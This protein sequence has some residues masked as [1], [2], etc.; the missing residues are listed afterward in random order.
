MSHPPSVDPSW[1]PPAWTPP[2]APTPAGAWTPWG[3]W[4]PAAGRPVPPPPLPAP[5]ASPGR[6]GRTV[7]AATALGAAGLVTATVLG[8][9]VLSS[10]ADELG[11]GIGA[12][13]AEAVGA[14]GVYADPSWT[15]GALGP[16]E[17]SDPVEPD[18]LG[19]DPV[20]DA[21]AQSCFDGDLQACDDLFY[22]SPPLS[23]YEEYGSTCGG[24][25]RQYEVPAC[26]DLD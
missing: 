10:A 2:P 22:E 20:L 4:D 25:V 12:G 6:P 26:T 18:E 5:P 23:G 11:R 19:P 14:G 15:G 3:T 13:V 9:L 21:Y 8:A 16:V 1:E 17:Q 7:L 24:R